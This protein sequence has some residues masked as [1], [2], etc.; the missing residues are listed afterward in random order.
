MVGRRKTRF[1]FLFYIREKQI[2]EGWRIG[3][4]SS[5]HKKRDRQKRENYGGIMVISTLSRLYGR[6]L[7]DRI[8]E[9]YMDKESEEQS[10]FRAGRSCTDNIFCLK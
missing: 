7:R 9:E 1:I 6:I 8:E 4:M 3:H 5:L 10:G 2:P